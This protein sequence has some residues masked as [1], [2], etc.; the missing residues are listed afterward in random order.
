MNESKK[1]MPKCLIMAGGKGTRLWPLSRKNKPKQF[2][3]LTSDKTMLQETFLR[4]RKKYGLNDIY[5]STST[6]YESE[7]EREILELP[8]HHIIA[9][10]DARGTAS[11]IALAS[12]L[13]ARESGPNTLLGMFPSDHFLKHEEMLV[14]ALV[15]AEAFLTEYPDYIVT[16]G[17]MPNYPE[18]GYGYIKKGKDIVSDL[19]M[20]II[21]VDRFV[22]KPD[23][24]TAEKYIE[25]GE[26][27][28]NSGIYVFRVGAML[29][30]L[31]KYVP[32]THKRAMKIYETS[33]ES[34]QSVIVEEYPF[35]DKINIEYSVIENDP[36][37]AV[38][39][40]DLGWSD[41]GSWSSL[42]DTLTDD[43]A[44]HFSRGEHIDFD[45]E[46]L[47]V[48]GSKKL[49]VTVGLKDLV[50]IDTDDA[51]LICDRKDAHR[52]SDV[53]KKLEESNHK[54]L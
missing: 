37:V 17:I 47:L 38:M 1:N 18:T 22:E 24:L 54:V 16:F 34:M 20:P 48:H 49:I 3:A 29:D 31:G 50:I 21:R 7:V 23:A 43:I 26:Y 10:P 2:Q 30:K 41:V 45:S 4:L 6:E 8:K 35:M 28:W 52:I 14:D 44:G 19:N 27:L 5:V 13:I 42:K 40:L 39:P 15:K 11:S 46:N 36:D 33:N 9:E 53:V 51:V 12:A 25:T 32:D